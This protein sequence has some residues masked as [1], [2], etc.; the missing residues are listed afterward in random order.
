MEV[1][2]KL[3]LP[4]ELL[5]ELIK[6]IPFNLK[7]IRIRISKAFDYF[8]SKFQQK[9]LINL[10]NL[11]NKSIKIVEKILVSLEE[12]VDDSDFNNVDVMVT[13]C[14]RLDIVLYCKLQFIIESLPSRANK[15]ENKIKQKEYLWPRHKSFNDDESFTNERLIHFQE[16]YVKKRQILFELYS[17]CLKEIKQVEQKRELY[18]LKSYLKYGITN[19]LEGIYNYDY[20]YR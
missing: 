4:N 2:P 16:L 5:S 12:K 3:K 10:I 20:Y 9:Y 17:F 14:A 19:D 11:R 1:K 7:W 13:L 6:F 8:L 15:I 18:E